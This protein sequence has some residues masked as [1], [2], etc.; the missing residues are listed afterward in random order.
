MKPVRLSQAAAAMGGT[1]RGE[2][3]EITSVSTDSRKCPPG[4]LFVPL[5]GEK[6][7]GHD[8]IAS[9]AATCAAVVTHKDTDPG[10]P[11][12]L[13]ED[14]LKALGDFAAWYRKE[15]APMLVAVTGSVG[16][17]TTKEMLAAMLSEKYLTACTAGNFNNHIGLPLTLLSMEEGTQAAVAEMG[18]NHFG[19]ISYLSKIASPDIGLITFTGTQHIE[20]LGSREG[21]VQA[22][23]EILHGMTP[24]APIVLN[25]D[26]ELLWAKRGEIGD[27]AVWFGIENSECTYTARD[28]RPTDEGTRFTL[29]MPGGQYDAFVP[30][31]GIHNVKNALGAA[32]AASLMGVEPEKTVSALA[33]FENTGMRQKIYNENGFTVIEDCYNAGPESMAASLE[34]LK[35]RPG[36]RIAVLGDMLELGEHSRELHEKA[37]TH[38]AL[39][40][41]ELYLYGSEMKRAISAAGGKARHFET[42]DDLAAALKEGCRGG[43]TVLF[44]GSRGMK[45]EEALKKFLNRE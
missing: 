23:L 34:V 13:V 21:I 39:C 30:A 26:C 24:D 41:D 11:S 37:L 25:G 12:V 7:D 32:A 8:Y 28:I 40:A 33:R 29:V 18:M 36:R 20:Y 9:A 16:K 15:I 17:T 5:V 38:G 3:I 35:N 44:K 27:R 19:E 2:D 45:M 4:S 31:P 1:L 10:V 22:K 42:H 6:A 14:T 43:E